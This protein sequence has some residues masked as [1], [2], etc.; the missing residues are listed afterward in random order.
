[1]AFG[2]KKLSID[3][4]DSNRIKL[5]KIKEETRTPY[6]ST[7]NTLIDTF[8]DLPDEISQDIIDTCKAKVRSL[9]DQMDKAG[10]FELADISAKV[11]KYL[12]IMAFLNHGQAISI[13]QI[14]REPEMKTIS[15]KNGS[16]IY[17]ANWIVVNADQATQCEYAGVVECRNAERYGIPHF[18]FF[19]NE[20]YA[21]DYSQQEKTRINRLCAYASRLFAD[22]EK[23]QVPLVAD[24][25]HPGEYLNSKEHLD[26]PYIGHF[27]LYEQ[28]DPT[29]PSDYNPPYGAMVVR[30]S[31]K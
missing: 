29:Y 25:E 14:K 15:I 17:P 5:E 22:A 31:Q 20:K 28:G 13:D 6:G 7:I 12:D 10:G 27:H 1:M 16:V 4:P 3:L 21:K 19:T 8:C 30:N 2:G 11:Q 18:L 24:P 9:L 23:Q 26:S